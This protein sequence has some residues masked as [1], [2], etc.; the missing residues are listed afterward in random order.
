MTQ[1]LTFFMILKI[2]KLLLSSFYRNKIQKLTNF[3]IS[4]INCNVF[5]KFKNKTPKIN[6]FSTKFIYKLNGNS[7]FEFFIALFADFRVKI[8]DLMD[9]HVRMEIFECI[10]MTVV[11]L[12]TFKLVGWIV[13][14]F[15]VLSEAAFC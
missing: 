7:R 10:A 1:N 4:K 12:W 15:Y 3:L 14:H 2:K 9:S 8:D 6:Q 5:N 13:S 11:T